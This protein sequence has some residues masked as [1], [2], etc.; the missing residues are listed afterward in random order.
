M[1][2]RFERE[3]SA[4]RAYQEKINTQIEERFA[5]QD[6]RYKSVR[7]FLELH[8][9]TVGGIQTQLASVQDDVT[10]LNT[11]VSGVVTGQTN[12][13]GKINSTRQITELTTQKID[14]LS[15]NHAALFD[16][17]NSTMAQVDSLYTWQTK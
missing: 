1:E 14:A 13:L 17:L 12:L 2:T 11:Q 3:R 6:D 10:R 4:R 9:R 7:D 5:S 8:R 16:D 15:R